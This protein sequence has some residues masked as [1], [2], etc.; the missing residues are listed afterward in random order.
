MEQ[1]R[2]KFGELLQQPQLYLNQL[3]DFFIF[4]FCHQI[5]TDWLLEDLQS[6]SLHR[7]LLSHE[8]KIGFFFFYYF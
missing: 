8:V 1:K 2:D 6:D 7:L 3:K 4:G 5:V